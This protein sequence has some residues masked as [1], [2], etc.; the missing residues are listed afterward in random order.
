M[1]FVLTAGQRARTR[2]WTHFLKVT[3]ICKCEVVRVMGLG[4][5]SLL[6]SISPGRCMR[7]SRGRRVTHAGNRMHPHPQPPSVQKTI[8]G[9][10]AEARVC[11]PLSA[12]YS[13]NSSTARPKFMWTS[14]LAISSEEARI[15][16]PVETRRVLPP[17]IGATGEKPRDDVVTGCLCQNDEVFWLHRAPVGIA[18]SKTLRRIRRRRAPSRRKQ[19]F[20]AGVLAA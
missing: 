15:R 10:F 1:A 4:R 2:I 20:L 11:A 17:P 13:D 12:A 18:I 6:L 19:R 7:H 14:R 8:H 9:S 16:E 5:D 3:S